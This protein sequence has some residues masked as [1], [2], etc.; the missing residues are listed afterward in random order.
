MSKVNLKFYLGARSGNMQMQIES[1]LSYPFIVITN[2]S[3]WAE[4]AGELLTVDAFAGQPE[5]HWPQFANTIHSHFI[6]GTW[7]NLSHCSSTF[8]IL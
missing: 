6:Q 2:E 5:I 8:T 7:Q 4:A 1:T 3:Q